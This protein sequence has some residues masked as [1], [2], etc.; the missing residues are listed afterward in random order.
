MSMT[1]AMP[2]PGNGQYQTQWDYILSSFP[3]EELVVVGD[4]A[5]APK[6]NVFGKLRATYVDSLANES[7]T[8]ILL[9]AENGRIAGDENL[10]DFVHPENAMY[11][12]GNDV[13]WVTLDQIGRE[14]DHKVYIPTA[15]RDDL[16]SW[17]AYA[18]TAWDRVMKNG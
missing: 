4:E 18:I 6:S 5:D 3:P 17:Q 9:A 16:F 12:F 13:A 11:L 7:R 10:A 2:L 14:P 15:T 8:L 1:V